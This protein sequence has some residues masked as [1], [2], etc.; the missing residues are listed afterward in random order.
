EVLHEV[1]RVKKRPRQIRGA[2]LRFGLGVPAS[3]LRRGVR[4][5]GQPG[6]LDHVDGTGSAR[7]LDE[8]ALELDVADVVMGDE[9]R[10]RH[11][12]EGRPQCLP[13]PELPPRP[14]PPAPPPPPR[15]LPPPPPA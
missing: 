14:P 15:P 9:E 4:R 3:A 8:V 7:R 10:A 5:R 6:E 11:A 1:G 2:D 12:L 13:P